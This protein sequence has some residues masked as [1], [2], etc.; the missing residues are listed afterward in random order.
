MASAH[1]CIPQGIKSGYR[2]GILKE[3]RAC[4]HVR[5]ATEVQ[6]SIVQYV[7]SCKSGDRSTV[8]CCH[9][10]VAT[11]VQ[12]LRSHKLRSIARARPFTRQ[13]SRCSSPRAVLVVHARSGCGHA[14]PQG[15]TCT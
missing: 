14:R 5:V 6:Y 8:Q 2:S 9:V 10:R 11:E 15:I 12:Y 3:N 4:C 1:G 13:T 7:L